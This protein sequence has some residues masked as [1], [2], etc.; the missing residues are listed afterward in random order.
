MLLHDRYWLSLA[1]KAA[2][3]DLAPDRMPDETWL[4]PSNRRNPHVIAI[5]CKDG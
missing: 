4:S 2:G 5:L 1:A 3:A